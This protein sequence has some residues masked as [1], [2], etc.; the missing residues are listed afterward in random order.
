MNSSLFRFLIFIILFLSPISLSAEIIT[1][2]NGDTLHAIVTKRTDKELYI[3]HTN[4]GSFTILWEHIASINYEGKTAPGE[5]VTAIPHVDKGLF[6][7]RL[8]RNW[9]RSL[10][11]GLNGAVGVSNNSKFRSLYEMRYKDHKRRWHFSMFYLLTEENS[12]VEENRLTAN[13]IRDWL[14]PNSKWFYFSKFGYDWDRF[15]DWDYRTR[16]SAGL[17]YE[18]IKKDNLKLLSRFGPSTYHTEGDENDTTVIE[19]DLGV[20]M[21]WKIRDK[22][23]LGFTNDFYPSLSNKG[24]YRNVTTL[25]WKFDLN[26]YRN[27][28]VKF[29]LYNELDS[30]EDERYDFKYSISLVL[31]L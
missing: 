13:L 24:E 29:G 30:S 21:M 19:A 6:Y 1:L 26:H 20:E 4:L 18:F 25:D 11:V 23:T 16:S 7:S 31:G 2:Q 14:L 10:E 27:M 15:K 3:K 12:E 22:H 8:F 17:G 9:K 5:K 28:G